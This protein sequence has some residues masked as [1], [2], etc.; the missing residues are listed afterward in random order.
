MAISLAAAVVLD[1][2]VSKKMQF[3]EHFCDGKTFR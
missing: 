1:L 3:G 2:P